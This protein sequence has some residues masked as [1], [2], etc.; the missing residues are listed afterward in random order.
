MTELKSLDIAHRFCQRMLMECTGK[1][2][3]F[4]DYLGITPAWV[5][6][7][8][9]KLEELYKVEIHYCHRRHTYYINE[10]GF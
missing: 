1:R 10:C 9:R 8:K 5:T 7:Y 6:I 3:D 4:A 2:S